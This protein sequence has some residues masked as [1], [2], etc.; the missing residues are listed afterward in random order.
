MFPYHLSTREAHNE[1]AD[2]WYWYFPLLANYSDSES[3][4]EWPESE[5]AILATNLLLG[6]PKSDNK[7]K[8]LQRKQYPCKFMSLC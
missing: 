5:D 7:K 2:L 4:A 1:Q 8:C 6:W 3:E